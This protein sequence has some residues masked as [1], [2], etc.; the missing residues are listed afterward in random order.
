M[1][2]LIGVPHI[3]PLD[4]SV[5]DALCA[6]CARHG[7]GVEVRRMPQRPVDD[8][9]NRLAL[10]LLKSRHS[11]ILYWDADM[12]PL[13]SGLE[14]LLAR[15]KDIVSGLAFG[16]SAPH[17]PVSLVEKR[18]DRYLVD[19]DETHEFLLR[20][21]SLWPTISF[22]GAALPADDPDVL[23]D[24]AAVGF[25]FTLVRREVF[26]K[27]HPDWKAQEL[28]VWFKTEDG[29]T[30][31][32][33]HFCERVKEKGVEM[34]LDRSVVVGHGYGDQHIGPMAWLGFMAYAKSLPYE[35]FRTVSQLGLA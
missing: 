27:A 11:H 21:R 16:R 33:V 18:G 6:V 35:E 7:A 13:A 2:I 1:S 10:E 22:K 31:E 30:G 9:R 32:D 8:A 29:V 3:A 17:W 24:R 34:W 23:V 14:R 4:G 12:R 20:Y 28:P 25:A 19:V 26:E 5:V 15:D